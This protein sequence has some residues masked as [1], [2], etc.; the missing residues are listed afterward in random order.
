MNRR[1]F[2]PKDRGYKNYGGRGIVVCKG[3]QSVENFA[4]DMGAPPEGLSID[5][6]D[7]DGGYWCGHCDECARNNWPK[8]CRWTDWETQNRNHRS[9]HYITALGKTMT[10]VEW[11][12]ETR[13]PKNTIINR[14]KR[15]WSE[16]DAITKPVDRSKRR[17]ASQQ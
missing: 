6:I 3:W 13:I 1:C 2:N 9:N 17:K 16:E 7:N 11:V 14:L 12:G 4:N 15:G 10:L 8:N 5:R